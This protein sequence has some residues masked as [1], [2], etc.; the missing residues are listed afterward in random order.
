MAI[1]IN[2]LKPGTLAQAKLL[3]LLRLVHLTWASLKQWHH[4]VISLRRDPLAW[5]SHTIAQNN[6]RLA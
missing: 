3:A 1:R 2:S 6:T 4:H 5:A